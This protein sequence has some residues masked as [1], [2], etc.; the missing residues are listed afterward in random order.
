MKVRFGQATEKTEVFRKSL[1]PQWNADWFK[2]EVQYDI[3]IISDNLWH[4]K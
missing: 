2:F 3:L 4:I 1:N